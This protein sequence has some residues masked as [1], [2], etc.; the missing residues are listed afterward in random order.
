MSA[1]RRLVEDHRGRVVRIVTQ[2]KTKEMNARKLDRIVQMFATMLLVLLLGS[3][4][5]IDD[6][7]SGC[8]KDYTIDYDLQ[9]VTNMTL[10]LET[11]LQTEVESEKESEMSKALR[12]HLENIFT[13]FAH[14]IDLSFYDTQGDSLRLYHDRHIMDAS[15]ETYTL[16]L[17][18]R[19]YQHL[20]VAN[21]ANN[22]AVGLEG[23]ERCHDSRLALT[24]DRQGKPAGTNGGGNGATNG[25]GIGG[26]NGGGNGAT[27]SGGNAG[28]A[29]GN[30]VVGGFAADTVSSHTTGLFTARL[31]MTILAN[32]DQTFN[33]HLYMANCAAALVVDPR[34]HDL[35]RLRVYTTGFASRF[36]INDSTFVFAEKTPIVRT[37]TVTA[38]GTAERSYCSVNFPS[39][40][41]ADT[42]NVIVTN[43]P[44]LAKEGDQVLWQ[45]R[46]YMTQA[47]GTVTESVLSVYKP[48]RAGQLKIIRAWV[49]EQGAVRTQDQ[50]VGVSVTLK[51]NEG[52]HHEVEL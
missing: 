20:A 40:E 30:S 6:D 22:I 24:N 49:D 32:Q 14:D 29:A 13:D 52:N 21:V 16:H 42:R 34:G 46:A 7:L 19:D 18:M 15:E 10:E 44:F 5:L 27:N 11:E 8:D 31:P 38:A 36:N 47:D 48:L 9:L 23:D 33:V 41:P 37:S 43:E 4:S 39:R 35:D 45:F 25:G 1:A 50:T 26:T 51:W 3:C 2:R 28:S 12:R 17:P